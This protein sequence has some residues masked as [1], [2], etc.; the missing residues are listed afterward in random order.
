[1]NVSIFREFIE[2]QGIH[3]RGMDIDVLESGFPHDWSMQASAAT[4]LTLN[5]LGRKASDLAAFTVNSVPCVGTQ[6]SSRPFQ[7]M[8]GQ[9]NLS[10][11]TKINICPRT[12]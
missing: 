8:L 5:P 1:M 7:V 2:H 12:P 9:R 10:E 11:T 3:G 4:S 6:K